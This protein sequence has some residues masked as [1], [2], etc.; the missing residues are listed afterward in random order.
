MAL[1]CSPVHGINLRE[2]A[3]ERAPWLHH[4]AGERLDFGCHR[5]HYEAKRG[6]LV[7]VEEADGDAMSWK[8]H[9]MYLR[10][11]PSLR[12]FSP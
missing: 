5:T 11:P 3:L 1:V 12:G 4:N 10:L 2:M 9:G 6:Q 8:T 7:L